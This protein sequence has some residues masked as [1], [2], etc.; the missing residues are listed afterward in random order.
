MEQAGQLACQSVAQNGLL[1]QAS[2]HPN[3]ADGKERHAHAA[4]AIHK[5]SAIMQSSLP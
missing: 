5:Q 1:N 2:L 3:H 4:N